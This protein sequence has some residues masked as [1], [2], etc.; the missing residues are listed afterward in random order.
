[1]PNQHIK[2]TYFEDHGF[3]VSIS[4]PLLCW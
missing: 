4:N 3:K 2:L 1:M